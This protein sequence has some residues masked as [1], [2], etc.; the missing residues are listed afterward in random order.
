MKVEK[1]LTHYQIYTLLQV[2]GFG[3]FFVALAPYCALEDSHPSQM[4][5]E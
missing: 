5:T 4:K 3:I 1:F 2:I